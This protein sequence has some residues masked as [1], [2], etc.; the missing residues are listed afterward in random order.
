[1]RL[2][3][4]FKSLD[5]VVILLF[6]TVAWSITMV[7]S[8]LLYDYGLGFWGPNGHDGIWHIALAQNLANG[9]WE[10]P[11]FAGERI[12]NYHVG[13]DLILAFIHK[14]TFVPLINLYFQI[15]PPLLA[16]SIGY[17]CYRFV[18]QWK[19]SRIKSI[20]ATFF[21]YFGGSFG[22]IV[23]L[24]REG[25]I[26]GESLFWS[27]QSVSTLVNPPFALSILV[28]FIV[29]FILTGRLHDRKGLMLVAFLS[30]ILIQI[31]VYAGILVLIGLFAAGFWELIRRNGSWLVKVAVGS[32]IISILFIAP[33]TKSVEQMV[34]LRP[35]WF[36]ESM[37]ANPDR[38]YLP[39]LSEAMINYYLG[40][41]WIK[42]LLAYGA[43]FLIFIVGNLGTRVV[44]AIEMVRSAKKIR[45][46]DF[47]EV[48]IYSVVIVGIL[49]PLFFIQ[50]GTA[51]NTIQFMY[52]SLLFLGI[53]TGVSVGS[54]IERQKDITRR[55]AI[56][57]LIIVFTLPTTVATLI[58][59]YLPKRP[60]AKISNYELEALSFLRNETDGIVLTPVF[61]R[62]DAEMAASN[63]PRPL[64]LYESSAYVSAFSGKKTFLEDEVNLEITGFDWQGRK[65]EIIRAL[66][67]A[68]PQTFRS[69]LKGKNI[70]YI[71][72]IKKGET[73]NSFL[74]LDKI[75]E[76]DLVAIYKFD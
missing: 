17:F 53:L 4:V 34:V 43:V 23:T 57:I 3:N 15:I 20:A 54:F 26:D 70:T 18:Y 49:I 38:L 27:Q 41:N 12:K 52:Y 5:L 66:A 56:I 2:N 32:L 71:Y 65:K 42:A 48:F 36:L 1:M 69:F 50:T 35:F 51:W 33:T 68:S 76:N 9:S 67:S 47:V 40:G 73:Q 24:L 8:G 72:W 11:V 21:V 28:L 7:K 22:W 14:I 45:N 25:K 39:K 62:S 6:G 29:V 59:H 74:G 46:L 58:N 31:K 13:F 44:G 75:Y 19:K 10:M 63:P 37:V 61:S 60:P 55:F 64:Y 16:L 30:G